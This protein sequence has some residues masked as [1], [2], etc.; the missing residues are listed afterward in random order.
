MPLGG[1]GRRRPGP[2]SPPRAGVRGRRPDTGPSRET[3]WEVV[4]PL[5]RLAEVAH[6]IQEPR[7]ARSRPRRPGRRRWGAVAITGGLAGPMS[8]DPVDVTVAGRARTGNERAGRRRS[9]AAESGIDGAGFTT[10][11]SSASEEIAVARP[12]RPGSVGR[13]SWHR[14]PWGEVHHGVAGTDSGGG[15]PPVGEDTI[16]RI[17]SMTKPVT[18]VAALILVEECV[19]RLDDPV[20]RWLP[21]LADRQVLARPGARSTTPC[22]PTARSRCATC[23][24]SASGW[25]MD[26]AF[27]TRRPVLG[28]DGRAGA[29][30]RAAPPGAVRPSRTSG[31]AGCGTVPLEHQPGSGGCTTRAPTCSACSW[32]GRPASRS[33]AFLRERIFEPLGM[34]DTGFSVPAA[35]LDR[36]GPL[37]LERSRQRA[38]RGRTTAPTVSGPRPRRSRGGARA[39]V[40]AGRLPGVRRAPDGTRELPGPAHRLPRRRRDDDDQPAHRRRRRAASASTCQGGVGWGFGV[41]VQVRRTEPRPPWAPTAGTAASARPGPTI[42]P[43]TWSAC[44]SRTRRGRRRRRRR[45]AQDFWTATYAA[46]AD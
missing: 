16:F 37:L 21:E 15:G 11:G 3:G 35:D 22:P 27:S 29:R 12:R 14:R 5:G 17:S 23:S 10:T 4:D 24:R 39:R 26:F 43:R 18:A 46:F 42:R 36:F 34:R 6:V 30:R 28:G 9:R 13:A 7:T 31:C 20:D 40:D 1:V 2:A 25:G 38:P 45:C 19:L 8:P 33:S 44:S 41:G 32:P